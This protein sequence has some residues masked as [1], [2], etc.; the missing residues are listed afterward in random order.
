METTGNKKL[1][2]F[3]FNTPIRFN[4]NRPKAP[5]LSNQKEIFLMKLEKSNRR[6]SIN[7]LTPT[8]FSDSDS[9]ASAFPIKKNLSSM[10]KNIE[11]LLPNIYA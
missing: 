5:V 6:G 9:T 2:E 11:K 3:T 1:K 7:F 8:K 10:K 4:S